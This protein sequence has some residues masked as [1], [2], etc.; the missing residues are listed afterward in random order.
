MFHGGKPWVSDPN[1]PHYIAARNAIVK[2]I[3]Y[4]IKIFVLIFF[5]IEIARLF[6]EKTR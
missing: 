6:S 1:H 4:S 3:Q 5:F 2:G